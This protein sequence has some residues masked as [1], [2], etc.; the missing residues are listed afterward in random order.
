[1]NLWNEPI[2]VR[3][4]GLYPLPIIAPKQYKK[5][6]SSLWE[7]ELETKALAVMCLFCERG[8]VTGH[9]YQP[10]MN[11]RDLDPTNYYSSR[12]EGRVFIPAIETSMLQS[13]EVKDFTG[14]TPMMFFPHEI[15]ET[16][17]G[18]EA[19]EA[20]LF[21]TTCN[22]DVNLSEEHLEIRKRRAS[23]EQPT[24]EEA[25]SVGAVEPGDSMKAAVEAELEETGA[26]DIMFG[27]GSL[28][29]RHG[30]TV[31]GKT[32]KRMLELFG[33]KWVHYV[34]SKAGGEPV[35]MEYKDTDAPGLPDFLSLWTLFDDVEFGT[36]ASFRTTFIEHFRLE[37]I[38]LP[39]NTVRLPEQYN[40]LG[41]FFRALAPYREGVPDGQHRV[42]LFCYFMTS[43][44]HPDAQ[45]PLEQQTFEEYIEKP[46][47]M[48]PA[49][50]KKWQALQLFNNLRVKL[51][52]VPLPAR[53]KSMSFERQLTKLSLT[54]AKRQEGALFNIKTGFPQMLASLIETV[55]QKQILKPLTF[56][57]FWALGQ[58]DGQVVANLEALFI[59]VVEQIDHRTDF[60]G[61]VQKLKTT[62][63][64]SGKSGNWN[65]TDREQCLKAA[66]RYDCIARVHAKRFR[67][68][69]DT[70]RW[71]LVMEFMRLG[72]TD[73]AVLS[74]V[75]KLYT[76]H[77]PVYL[78]FPANV[79]TASA[80]HFRT[81]DW[82][83]YHIMPTLHRISDRVTERI[84][85]E[86]AL[87]QSMRRKSMNWVKA[88][89]R[90]EANT[91]P[92]GGKLRLEDMI[93]KAGTDDVYIRQIPNKLFKVGPSAFGSSVKSNSLSK[94]VR[95][96]INQNLLRNVVWTLNYYGF[97][98]E[99]RLP[100]NR[101]NELLYKYLK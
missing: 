45:A 74:D 91:G 54:G 66:S 70:L 73:P 14:V 17:T 21:R 56:D 75:S 35:E 38:Y 32:F 23:T 47:L 62:G 30:S 3:K 20:V 67:G 25:A 68:D 82:A 29:N 89:I 24:D 39:R 87:V 58:K 19:S 5:N 50:S 33:Y 9:F 36:A 97:S 55:Q 7:T 18:R 98:P 10:R 43:F 100:K 26:E 51:A 77:N 49:M 37:Q 65:T 79:T 80:S 96:H 28:L 52:V 46:R 44:F 42:T 85:I 12:F 53:R 61:I 11:H 59:S 84:S 63:E 27:R 48:P 99:V 95:F 13:D 90:N 16:P 31:T 15:V 92:R 2:P 60:Q 86:Q 57:N 69:T 81:L 4:G 101:K 72:A 71:A 22:I 88:D 40:D 8:W 6:E 83:L 34:D 64:N 94:F 93:E 1:M 76:A 41:Q 78:Q